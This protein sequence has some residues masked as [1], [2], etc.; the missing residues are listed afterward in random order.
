MCIPYNIVVYPCVVIK[1]TLTDID[2]RVTLASQ[3]SD[4]IF[5]TVEI[6]GIYIFGNTKCRGGS[7]PVTL[8]PLHCQLAEMD[9]GMSGGGGYF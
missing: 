2:L 1:V 8:S 4:S 6:N 3:D 5:Y 7:L 9:T